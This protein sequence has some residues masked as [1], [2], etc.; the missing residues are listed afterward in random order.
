MTDSPFPTPVTVT[1][2]TGYI[3]GWVVR[4]LLARGA[5]VH[6]T[7][8]SMARPGRVAHLRAMEDELP[9]TLKLFEADL[10][11]EGSFDACIAECGVVIHMAS[12]FF[13]GRIKDPEAELVRPALEG[14]RNVLG[15]V[16]R[17]RSVT[18]VVVTSSVAAIYCDPTDCERAGGVLNESHWNTRA[19]ASYQPYPY[20]KAVAERAAWELHDAQDRWSLATI[21]P[22]F[23]MGP[24]ASGRTD[25]TSV[26]FVQALLDGTR[27][28]GMPAWPTGVVD[29][30]DVALAHVQAALRPDAEGRFIL[31]ERGTD[32]FEMSEWLREAFGADGYRLPRMKLPTPLQ[33]V[34]GP[35]VAGFS[36]RQIWN[37]NRRALR[38]DNTRSREILGIEYRSARQAVIDLGQQLIDAGVVKP[39]G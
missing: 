35:L 36:W 28:S 39:P 24:S 23:V 37:T 26:G 31:S 33:Y 32:W 22:S 27:A 38:F 4:E 12:P 6:G 17:T 5:T 11:T 8:R 19:S 34:I 3:A 15:S 1:G 2:A 18:R 29:V 25:G 9:G 14:T 30:R 21:N 10:L 7:V 13:V 16:E 20:S